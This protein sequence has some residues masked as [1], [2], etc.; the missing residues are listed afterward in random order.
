MRYFLPVSGWLEE[1]HVD[2]LGSVDSRWANETSQHRQVGVQVAADRRNIGIGNAAAEVRTSGTQQHWPG[3]IGGLPAGLSLAVVINAVTEAD[4]QP[5][6]V[7]SKM[8]MGRGPAPPEEARMLQTF[9]LV[10]AAAQRAA[11]LKMSRQALTVP[12]DEG[13]RHRLAA[14]AADVANWDLLEVQLRH[15]D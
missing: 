1:A 3:S 6:S 8:L 4:G 9:C 7:I 10:A 13:T 11:G 12:M 14:W 2:E 5:P 15:H